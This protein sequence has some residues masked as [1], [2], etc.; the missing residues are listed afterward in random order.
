MPPT[1]PLWELQA[2]IKESDGQC[3]RLKAPSLL[4]KLGMPLGTGGPTL[5]RD[6]DIFV[7][8]IGSLTHLILEVV[9]SQGHQAIKNSMANI[10]LNHR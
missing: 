10:S 2:F 9:T 3:L 8:D 7:Y 1:V 6:F 5:Q 4:F